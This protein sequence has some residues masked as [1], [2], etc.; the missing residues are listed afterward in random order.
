MK[1]QAPRTSTVVTPTPPVTR[2]E[3]AVQEAAARAAFF[4][5]VAQ[6]R[7]AQIKQYGSDTVTKKTS[8]WL[9]AIL[10]KEVAETAERIAVSDVEATDEEVL[11]GIQEA[12]VRSGAVVAA[13]YEWYQVGFRD[14]LGLVS[15]AHDTFPEDPWADS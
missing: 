10:L 1:Q 5:A 7:E 13:M 14:G 8:A 15:F 3:I 2:E 6:E 9:L 11:V 12:L 4:T